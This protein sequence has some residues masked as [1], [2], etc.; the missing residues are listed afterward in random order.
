M[1]PN[2]QNMQAASSTLFQQFKVSGDP[3]VHLCQ[4]YCAAWELGNGR[5]CKNPSQMPIKY[6]NQGFY[7]R[8]AEE[9]RQF[10]SPVQVARP[11]GALCCMLCG[12]ISVFPRQGEAAYHCLGSAIEGY[13][14]LHKSTEE[15]AMSGHCTDPK[16]S[17]KEIPRCACQQGG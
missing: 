3:S 6:T 11:S 1:Q 16:G 14:G 15:T 12:S 17:D 7:N 13:Q 9:I 5:R 10:V 4:I 2:C 8:R